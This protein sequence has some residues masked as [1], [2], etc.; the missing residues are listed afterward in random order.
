M[1]ALILSYARGAFV[2]WIIVQ[3]VAPLGHQSPDE[4][5]DIQS[6]LVVPR[7]FHDNPNSGFER[8]KND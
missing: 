7:S 1:R 2:L 6:D 8:G 5:T 4:M 3:N